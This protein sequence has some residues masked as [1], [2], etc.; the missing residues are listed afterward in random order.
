MPASRPPARP[1]ST[2]ASYCREHTHP[3]VAAAASPPL[4][5]APLLPALPARCF[6]P[7]PPTAS[8]PPRPLL[9]APP[10]PRSPLHP[11]PLVALVL[12]PLPLVARVLPA[13]PARCC[14]AA[15]HCF[16]PSPPTGSRPLLPALPACCF[17]PPPAAAPCLLVTHPLRSLLPALPARCAAAYRPPR[18][19]LPSPPPTSCCR[20]WAT[21]TGA[22]APLVV[23]CC[24]VRCVPP[25][26]S[27]LRPAP[28]APPAPAVA[29]GRV[30][31]R[32]AQSSSAP[33]QRMCSSSETHPRAG[34]PVLPRPILPTYHRRLSSVHF[35]FIARELLPPLPPLPR[36]H[37]DLR[38]L[39]L[40]PAPSA[41]NIA[42]CFNPYAIAPCASSKGI[43]PHELA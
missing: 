6:P 22:P 25:S 36:S 34:Q 12:P 40:H 8:R 30:L 29:T 39:P 18:S 38:H 23:G 3:T 26:R 17:L 33:P 15:S 42:A 14:P 37:D 21:G 5:V 13:L 10:P 9:P 35:H 2:A 32:I 20:S 19:L 27:S 28:T 11:L 7:S 24:T 43:C 4:V 31:D 41:R 1:A 16:P